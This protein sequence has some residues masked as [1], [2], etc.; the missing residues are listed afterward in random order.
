MSMLPPLLYRGS[1]KN[2]RGE[3]SAEN[4]LFEF[5]DRYSVFDWGE[6]PDQLEGK[7]RALSIMGKMFFYHLG[8]PKNWRDLFNSKIIQSTFDHTYLEKL[9]KSSVYEHLILL[10]LHHHALFKSQDVPWNSEYLK[11]KKIDVLRPLRS[12]NSY[13]Y[14]TYQSR[15]T[16][17]LVPLEVI[18][19]IGLPDGN[20]LSKR[21][22][23][24][25]SKWN[26]YGFN[27]IPSKGLLAKPIID[28][29]TKLERGDRYLSYKEAKTISGMNESEWNSMIDL[30]HL[31]ALN[32]FDLHQ[33]MG[34]ELWDGKIEMAFTEGGDEQR[35]FMLVDSIGID[36]LRLLLEGKSFSKEFLREA[37]KNSEW[38]ENLEKAKKDSAAM[39]GDFKEICQNKYHSSPKKLDADIKARAEA[40][41][42]SYCNDLCALLDEDFKTDI[43][44]EYLPFGSEFNLK[45]YCKRYL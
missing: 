41:Y 45:N 24:D 37:Y 2:I 17:A 10:G 39:G 28:F 19:R 12:E 43:T 36:E 30:T 7:G 15:P 40:V 29:S 1:V 44:S 21:L 5:S 20:S 6:M 18:F 8:N 3:V 23:T 34:L 22:G 27:E 13:D 32:L 25:L 31:I 42:K 35:M 4:L 16:N 26:K 38:Y 11:V 33:R 14:Q 9:Q